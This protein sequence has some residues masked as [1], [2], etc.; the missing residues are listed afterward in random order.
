VT[1]LAL[2]FLTLTDLRNSGAGSIELLRSGFER[3]IAI[4][5]AGSL[6]K[7]SFRPNAKYTFLLN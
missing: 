5:R 4:A 2:L 6:I 3:A 7:P 1:V